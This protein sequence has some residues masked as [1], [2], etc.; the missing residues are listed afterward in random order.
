MLRQAVVEVVILQSRYSLDGTLTPRLPQEIHVR[1][2][3][4]MREFEGRWIHL[5]AR[6][7]CFGIS[8]RLLIPGESCC[9]SGL[10][11]QSD[12]MRN[13]V[14]ALT[15]SRVHPFGLLRLGV[16]RYLIDVQGQS[17]DGIIELAPVLFTKTPHL[18]IDHPVVHRRVST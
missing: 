14:P 4:L 8:D 10:V 18:V 15:L 13:D 11:V 16:L 17:S 3:P 1:V 12:F 6:L 9:I 2:R 7:G 5:I